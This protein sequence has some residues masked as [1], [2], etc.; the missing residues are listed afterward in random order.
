MCQPRHRHV[1]RPAAAPTPSPPPRDPTLRASDA[2]RESAVGVLREH[3]GAGRLDVEEL[4]QRVGAAYAARTHGELQDLFRDLP[5]SPPAR[6]TP[7][8]PARQG[9][10]DDGGW[11]AFVAVNVL[12][13]AIWA[14][15]GA[16]YFWPAWV[17][18]WWGFALVMKSHASRRALVTASRARSLRLR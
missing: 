10:G 15:S 2:E 1:D 7:A 3:G 14:F 4:E 12:L 16:G 8:R 17:I 5:A 11:A 13:V 18:A 9:A 6:R